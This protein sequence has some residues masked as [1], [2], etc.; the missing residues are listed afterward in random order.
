MV[1][2]LRAVALTFLAAT[3]SARPPM[4][5]AATVRPAESLNGARSVLVIS[6]P[7][8]TW[9]DLRS[10]RPPKLTRL[11]RH[12]AVADLATRTVQKRTLPGA[13]YMAFGAGGRA[14]ANPDDAASN[15]EGSERYA[16]TDAAAVF[17]TR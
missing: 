13:G 1:H 10:A 17:A 15:V 4:A 9:M 5:G 16:G 11:L 7:A 2:R 14:V 3:A 8:T 6:L 12:S